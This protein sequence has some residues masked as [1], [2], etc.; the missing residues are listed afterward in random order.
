MKKILTTPRALTAIAIAIIFF[1]LFRIDSVPM[2][3]YLDETSIGINAAAIAH[4]GT[5]EH[6]ISW[7]IYFKAFG[8]NKNP[9]Y[10][11]ATAS[12]F[13]FFGVSE[14]NLRMTSGLFFLLST[15]A[16]FFV[17]KTLFRLRR[18]LTIFGMISFG[19]LPYFFSVS[20]ISFEVI[21]YVFWGTMIVL[22]AAVA[23]KKNRSIKIY[24]LFG[25]VI[26]TSIYT[27]S[28]A[29]LLS[30][31][32]ICILILCA[33]QYEKGTKYSYL[34]IST[35][36]VKALTVIFLAFIVSLTPYFLFIAENPGGLTGRF[37]AISYLDDPIPAYEKVSLFLKNYLQYWG[38]QFLLFR[39]EG[40]LRHSIGYAGALYVTTYVLGL[41]ALFCWIRNRSFIHDKFI[42]FF[43]L[44]WITAPLAAATINEQHILRT[45]T[46]GI[47]WVIA[48]V[49]GFAALKR[50]LRP[51]QRRLASALVITAI[52]AEATLYLSAYFTI[53]PERSLHG[54]ESYGVKQAYATALERNPEKIWFLA[55]PHD[56][57][58][59]I[60]FASLTTPNP[61]NIPIE[62]TSSYIFEARQGNC[63][64]YHHWSENRLNISYPIQF[65]WTESL[66]PNY[67][68]KILGV[69]P[70]EYVARLI[71]L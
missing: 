71:C 50:A 55:D 44:S 4:N 64:I 43:L 7:P 52:S 41:V 26:G 46:S 40:N 31:I 56:S 62:I 9:I 45:V 8:E 30:A 57:Y 11:Y 54:S 39:G 18:D 1:H 25:L 60:R 13:K 68:Q 69:A 29:R 34:A 12:L 63:V 67:L 61:N 2:G 22:A 51:E 36:D 15:T 47:Y 6:G 23:F 14:L 32:S 49:Y 16:F 28:T 53:F 19:F 66:Q 42:R 27:Y 20:R 33:V 3:L 24:L 10:I 65:K 21:S 5:D 59:N 37:L 38:P 48:S 70:K 35:R 58:A 17:L